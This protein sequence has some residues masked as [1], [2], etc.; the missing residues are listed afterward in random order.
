MET[1]ARGVGDGGRLRGE[2]GGALSYAIP[3][4]SLPLTSLTWSLQE[5]LANLQKGKNPQKTGI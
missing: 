3:L 2:G 4:T 5:V 1:Y